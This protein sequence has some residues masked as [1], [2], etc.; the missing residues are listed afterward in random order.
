MN[1]VEKI[2]KA[3]DERTRRKTRAYDSVG[4]VSKVDGNTVWVHLDNGVSETPFAK[5]ISCKAGDSVRVRVDGGNAYIIGND[6]APPTDD[7]VANIAHSRAVVADTKATEAKETA[8]AVEGIAT[9]AMVRASEAKQIAD[10]TEQHFWFTETGAD[11][12]AHI[13]EVTQEE[14]NDSGDP[15]YQSGGNLLARSNGI[16]VRD[17][18]TELA[19]MAATGMTFKGLDGEG[20]LIDYFYVAPDATLL[21]SRQ[22][23]VSGQVLQYFITPQHDSEGF[24]IY[25]DRA[26]QLSQGL[27]GVKIGKDECFFKGTYDDNQQHYQGNAVRVSA[28][29][30]D[31]I[32]V[33]YYDQSGNYTENVRIEADNGDITTTGNIW[34]DGNIEADGDMNCNG[35]MSTA[36]DIVADGSLTLDN[37]TMV[38]FVTTKGKSGNWYYEKY[39]SGKVEAW[40][41]AT[42]GTLTMSGS[43]RVYVAQNVSI[44]N[45]IPS[46]IF[47]STPTFTEVST[48]YASAACYAV[49]GNATSNRNVSLQI[50][51]TSNN[52]AAV[53]VQIHCIYYPSNY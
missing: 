8:S 28:D 36:G 32:E 22:A 35:N 13:T 12:G 34:A 14:W 16:A 42:T 53:T 49:S 21:R 9:S 23:I 15:N 7:A 17:G 51:K 20:N 24:H 46:G 27:E 10:D 50:V 18:L 52:T 3:I 4:T 19:S 31:G 26:A 40:G 5:S 1:D 37:S 29:D 39:K 30:G 38:D 45:A 43:N 33:G 11:T 41:T 47:S 6:T 25:L 44:T 48:N 2:I